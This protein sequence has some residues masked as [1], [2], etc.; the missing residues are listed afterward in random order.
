MS[1][2]KHKP[3]TLIIRTYNMGF[4]DCFLLT[5]AY[6]TTRD[7]HVLIDFGSTAKPHGAKSNF[8]D[9]VAK[10]I[11]EI[12][13]GRLDAVVATHR[14]K[15]HI[16]GFGLS[17]AGKIIK[18]LT[19]SI[20][21]QPWT[22]DP[23]I[24]EDADAPKT[25]RR[26]G[27]M[28]LKNMNAFSDGYFNPKNIKN[29]RHLKSAGKEVFERLKFI[30]EDNV[31]NKKA[32]K[33]LMEMGAAKRSAYVHAKKKLHLK[34]ILPGVDVD[35]LGPPTVKQH[36]G[37]KKQASR[38]DEYW[39][40]NAASAANLASGKG[41]PFPKHKNSRGNN[42]TKWARYRLK[43]IRLEMLYSIV[44][45]LDNALNNTSLILLFRAGERSFLF[46]GDAQIEN[47]E[48]ALSDPEIME[49]LAKVD[50]YKVGHHGS[51][52]AT[53]KSLWE[54]FDKKGSAN[55][56]GRMTSLL[57]TLAGH[58]GHEDR[59]TEVPRLSLVGALEQGS[60]L[61]ETEN[62]AHDRLFDETI[63]PLG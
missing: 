21:I 27:R 13:E 60:D 46:P 33:L 2:K 4:G 44:T 23:D 26:R 11:A 48:Y 45:D 55:D 17:K 28:R 9:D 15:D 7:R 1:R 3:H 43:Q 53:P 24:A 39:H 35:V 62:I 50:V 51:L 38:H 16:G 8:K 32:V 25:S 10:S 37:V 63:I 49:K 6:E 12:C 56:A 59:H 61:R 19:P 30:G 52:N 41:D 18:G 22:E 47:W 42:G 58:H 29:I 34:R 5:F 14:H 57:S 20:V 31:S 36:S 40:M 54:N